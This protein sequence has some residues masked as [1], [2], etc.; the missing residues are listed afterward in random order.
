MI[1]TAADTPALRPEQTGRAG[2]ARCTRERA[3]LGCSRRNRE[4][5]QASAQA[6]TLQRSVIPVG[7]SVWVEHLRRGSSR[8]AALLGDGQVLCHPV[9]Q[10][11]LAC[12]NLHRR[13]EILVSP[14]LAPIRRPGRARRDSANG[15]RG[16]PAWDRTGLDRCPPASLGAADRLRPVD[17]G[18]CTP[19]SGIQAEPFSGMIAP[20]GDRVEGP[21]VEARPAQ[22]SKK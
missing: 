18:P 20:R 13:Q 22:S 15:R 14:W 8:L 2:G 6:L 5:T 3:S 7:T 4:A 19:T 12:G 21:A 10:G 17:F 9:V 1:F 11:E 16:T